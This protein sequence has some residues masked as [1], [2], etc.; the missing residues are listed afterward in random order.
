MPSEAMAR[1][2]DRGYLPQEP[3]SPRPQE[4]ASRDLHGICLPPP[5]KPTTSQHRAARASWRHENHGS[6]QCQ[7]AHPQRFIRDIELLVISGV[8]TGYVGAYPAG[9]KT[10]ERVLMVL[11]HF[12]GHDKTRGFNADRAPELIVATPGFPVGP[13]PHRTRTPGESRVEKVI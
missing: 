10:S 5:A 12:L 13:S 6:R 1:Q 11:T 3:A 7:L 2:G 4:R 9:S 8:G